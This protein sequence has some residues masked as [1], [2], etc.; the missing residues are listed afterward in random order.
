LPV[1]I[2]VGQD[3][4]SECDDL[5]RFRINT[6]DW[7]L[8][9]HL[10]KEKFNNELET[11]NID[12][13]G[14]NITNAILYAANASIDQTKVRNVRRKRTKCLP[15]WNTRI[16]EIVVK[17]NTARNKMN[18]SKD[19]K[20]YD[21]YRRLK[22]QAQYVIKSTAKEHWRNYCTKLN[23]HSR[24]SSVWDA[25]KRMNGLNRKSNIPII[26]ENGRNY[27]TNLE[28]ANIFADTYERVSSDQNHSPEFIT[29]KGQL[30]V[31]YK[32]LLDPSN[33]SVSSAINSQLNE[34]FTI[35]ELKHAI[36]K[37][38]NGS[39]PGEDRISY[40]I[41]KHLP[42]LSRKIVLNY[43]N[44]IW[45]SGTIPLTFKHAI[46]LP[47]LKHGKASNETKSYRP[48]SLTNTLGK[49][50]ERMVTDRLVY[51]LENNNLLANTQTGFRKN[52]STLDQII[53]LQDHVHRNLHNKLHTLA[54]FIDFR[55]A[56][57]MLWSGGLLIKLDR[58]GING[59]TFNFIKSFMHDR[60]FQVRVGD[61]FSTTKRVQNGTPQGSPLSPILF[62]IAV[63]DLPE[64]IS[65]GTENSLF[66]D[67]CAL[68]T[69]NY[70]K[71]IGKS[72]FEMQRN[73]DRLYKWCNIWGFQISMDKTVCVLFSHNKNLKNNVKLNINGVSLKLERSAKFLGVVFDDRLTFTQHID[74]VVDKCRKRINL[75]KSLSGTEWGASRSTQMLI[76]KSLIRSV[77]DYGSIAYD[78]M[79]DSHKRKLD[80]IQ[81]Q[82]LKVASG[83]MISTSLSSLQVELGELPLNLRRKELQIKY[84]A[85]IKS[86]PD[87]P[88]R[89]VAQ[90]DWMVRFRKF[91]NGAAPS[92][93]KTQEFFDFFQADTNCEQIKNNFRYNNT[94]ISKELKTV[95]RNAEQ[96]IIGLWQTDWDKNLN[97]RHLYEIKSIVDTKMRKPMLPR[98]KDTLISRL[99]L[100][101]CG[102]NFYLNKIDLHESGNCQ[103]CGVRETIEHFL[104]ECNANGMSSRLKCYCSRNNID[105][106]LKNILNSP[107]CQSIIFENC[108][109][110]L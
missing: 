92:L 40:E 39:S 107:E 81:F 72:V 42:G 37:G 15:Y 7:V 84:L 2:T 26:C 27:D 103:A 97:G 23:P 57:D 71:R 99:R 25:V 64:L 87:H 65:A 98:K 62:L 53:K 29:N 4:T 93:I 11:N 82:A 32:E 36:K 105:F 33:R 74:Y 108:N 50:L 69:S 22:G 9:K 102:L 20:D 55:A 101:K 16:R 48:I 43:F 60:S 10:C 1:L 88:A 79:S 94:T 110:S 41:L 49:I 6:A 28:K 44:L 86:I 35:Q 85:K 91:K 95:Y 100:G 75:M 80:S 76:Y 12:E 38:K 13:L 58:M 47:I 45:K 78:V 14:R 3:I 90:S 109:R 67:D 8:F 66:A 30:E 63:N 96:Y 61:Q 54:V 52:K 70:N 31:K 56:F 18:R 89:K 77:L 46:V 5:P 73:L 34:P 104:L 68:Y 19:K 51:Y 24:V 17:R 83:A 21:N 59:E 106:N